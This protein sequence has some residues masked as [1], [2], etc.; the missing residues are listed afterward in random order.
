[1]CLLHTG[2]PHLISADEST[3]KVFNEDDLS[4]ECVVGSKPQLTS[5]EWTGNSNGIFSQNRGDPEIKDKLY[6]ETNALSWATSNIEERKTVHNT[7]VFCTA[8]N[9]YESDMNKAYSMNV[10]C[11]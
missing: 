8:A 7:Q 10:E 4:Y 3:I 9:G 5:F 2:P 11:K 6:V 1:M